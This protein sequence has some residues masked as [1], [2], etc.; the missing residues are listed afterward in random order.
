M[1]P[2]VQE[3]ELE[4][5]L[6]GHL[7]QLPC[8]EQRHL[9]LHLVLRAPTVPVHTEESLSGM[10]WGAGGCVRPCSTL[11]SSLVLA[12]VLQHGG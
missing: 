11:S 12:E 7:V 2:T 4:E 1:S 5:T 3:F 10:L 6:E 9:Q 8:S